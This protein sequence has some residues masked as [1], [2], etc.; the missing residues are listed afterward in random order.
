MS[1]PYL[2]AMRG[3][4][5]LVGY[6]PDGDSV[7]FVADDPS[8]YSHLYRGYKIR[9]SNRDGSVQLRLE[10]IDAP[11]LHYGNEA[12][13]TGDLAHD[14]LLDHIGVRKVE[15]QPGSTTVLT[16]TPNKIPAAIYTAASDPNGRAVSYLQV[17][18]TL[19]KDGTWTHMTNQILD[20]TVNAKALTSGIAYPTFYSSAPAS[21][22]AHLRQ[23]AASARDEKLGVWD[24]D[25]SGLFVL[26]DQN[27]ISPDGQ[28][29]LPKLFRRATDY[30]ADRAHGFRGNL[31]DWLRA[32]NVGTRHEDDTVIL[33]GG[34]E[35]PLS[36]LL[37]QRNSSISFTPDLLDITF[38]EK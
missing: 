17:G 14:W 36:S 8:L 18:G 16:A 32:N 5:V 10:G 4:L 26:K 27:S 34:V 19:P 1:S 9:R 33:Q 12:Q 6:Q 30:L 37:D 38:V 21:H 7:R 25:R 20:R 22:I 15:Y 23:L 24:L 28:L 31:A 3:H 2:L 13:P 11:E 29:I 35:V